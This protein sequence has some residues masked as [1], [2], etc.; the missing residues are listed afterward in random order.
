MIDKVPAH[1]R[2][3]MTKIQIFLQKQRF[4]YYFPTK[5]CANKYIISFFHTI[6]HVIREFRDYA[7]IEHPRLAEIAGRGARQSP[8]QG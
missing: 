2:N 8:A 4:M 7:R 6:F 1:K 3:Y 5:I